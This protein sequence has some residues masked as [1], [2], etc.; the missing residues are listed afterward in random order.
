MVTINDVSKLARVSKSTVSRV[1]SEKGFVSVDSRQR[2]Q[3]AI[4][5]L[6]YRPNAFARS[7]KSNRSGV[8]G[9]VVIDLSSPFYAQMLGGVQYVIEKADR[10]MVVC[11]GHADPEKESKVI[12]SLLALRC[13]G[14]IL[15]IEGELSPE[16]VDSLQRSQIPVV[17]IGNAIPEFSNSSIRVDNEVGGYLAT[18]YLLEMG[19][20]RIAHLTGTATY[21]DTQV[22]LRGFK[23]ALQEAGARFED[24]EIIHGDYFEEFGYGATK[25]LLNQ[26]KDFTAIFAGDDDIAAG[27]IAAL[28]E[29]GIDVP[30]E[31]SIVGF[32]DNFHA[33]H[34]HPKLTT[35]RQ[36]IVDVG[37]LAGDLL[38]KLLN[39]ESIEA[40]NR[41]LKPELIIRDSVKAR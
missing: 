13:D 9:V 31:I 19:H 4:K 20:R 15:N 32:D 28:K 29:A 7:L 2:V 12:E 1:I 23:Q 16:Q 37:Q 6:G 24:C 10:N 33:R 3:E 8:I 5:E 26:K 21:I 27:A 11:S 14:L 22:R 30:G 18:K 41:V 40:I 38:N 39:G 17:V 34:M 36:P 35:V 25:Q